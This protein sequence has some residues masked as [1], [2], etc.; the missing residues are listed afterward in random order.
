MKKELLLLYAL[1]ALCFSHESNA[2]KEQK[3]FRDTLDNALDL[4]DF[5][6]NHHGILPIVS[7]ITEPAVGYGA[8]VAALYFVTKE[9]KSQRPDIIIAAAGL[10]SNKTW[11]A[12]GGYIGFWKKDNIRYRGFA[13]YAEAN[14]K[15]YGLL[16]NR[17]LKFNLNA[18][19]FLQQ[20]NFRI[21]KSNFFLGGKYQL[22]KI[23]IPI[24]D[25]NIIP[26]I[27][28]RELEMWNS[29]ISAIA[30]FDNLNNFLSPTKGTKIHLSYDQNLEIIGS[31]RDWGKINF[32][33][34]MYLPITNKWLSAFR[35]DS[36]LATGNTPFYA[37]PFVSL[38]GVAALRYQGQLTALFETEQQFA[39]S[40]RWDLIGFTGIGAAFK[41]V[42]NMNNDGI[43]WNAG[44]GFRYLIARVLGMKMGLDIARGPEDWAFYVTAGTSWR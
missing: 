40:K 2:Q 7:P 3:K 43:V 42:E 44:G 9:D 10:T 14:L 18:F 20:L 22:A 38:R 34:Y 6:V 17:P 19:I 16:D 32:Y 11:L 24:F 23:T 1:I 15:Y 5:L 12:G 29:G 36:Q 26:G 39:I 28:P 30:E 13:G 41:N 35:V 31:N 37:E 4:S 27:N 25:N 33:T 8:A 21:G